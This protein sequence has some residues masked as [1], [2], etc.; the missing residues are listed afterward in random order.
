M[1]KEKKTFG[2]VF[3]PVYGPVYSPVYGPVYGPVHS[4]VYG[5]VYGQAFG[6]VCSPVY[7]H[8]MLRFVML[9]TSF[10]P[11][12]WNCQR[13]VSRKLCILSCMYV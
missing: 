4:P 12:A 8:E 7:S 10:G 3:D 11:W 5:P 2:P 13:K 9:T 1:I 6:P